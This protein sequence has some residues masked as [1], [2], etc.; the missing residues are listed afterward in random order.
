MDFNSLDVP[1]YAPFAIALPIDAIDETARDNVSDQRSDLELLQPLEAILSS[2]RVKFVGGQAESPDEIKISIESLDALIGK[3][4]SLTGTSQLGIS[5]GFD[6][7][8]SKATWRSLDYAFP[9]YETLDTINSTKQIPV[10]SSDSALEYFQLIKLVWEKRLEWATSDS[11]RRELFCD[12]FGKWTHYSG[13][14]LRCLFNQVLEQLMVREASTCLECMPNLASKWA[15]RYSPEKCPPPKLMESLYVDSSVRLLY[16]RD[17]YINAY[18]DAALKAKH[19]IDI[20]ACYIFHTDCAT[21]YIFLDLIP[22]LA[23]QKNIKVRILF[24][25]MTME[26]QCFHGVLDVI[27]P[28]TSASASTSMPSDVSFIEQLPSGSPPFNYA[29]KKFASTSGLLREILDLAA[30]IPNI[31]YQYWIARDKTSK[32]R[33]KNHSKFHIFD[34]QSGGRVIAGGSNVV[35]RP[36]SLDTDFIVEGDITQMYQQTFNN[37]WNAMKP[38][39]S[40]TSVFDVAEEKKECN[41]S[42]ESYDTNIA[43]NTNDPGLMTKMLFLSS[44]PS[45]SGE[46]VILRKVLGAIHAAEKSIV[47]CM[48]HCN[49]PLQFTLALQAATERGVKV[50]VLSNSIYSCDLRNGQKDL[51]ASLRQM[52]TVAPKVELFVTAMKGG[53]RPPFLHSK[54]VV[55]DANWSAFG[56][57]N[58]WNRSS[59]Y[60][61]EAN[62]FAFS[63]TLASQLLAK[64]EQEKNSYSVQVHS[65]ADCEFFLPTGLNG[66]QKCYVCKHFG[67]FYENC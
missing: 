32:Y 18:I 19:S 37:L 39:C 26:S 10:P 16:S 52:L 44:S 11:E 29:E 6:T 63:D 43:L 65:A 47:L 35:P 33:I 7:R 28:T 1:S 45:S 22:Y 67:P 59:F 13:D 40:N 3:L 58:L 23:T 64:F 42:H 17:N 66:D 60:E 4:S 34:G 46:D 38:F 41:E 5:P 57:W 20:C 48:G 61:M 53:R 56:S 27:K 30:A 36:D 51:F 21:K 15:E 62:V 24:E 8:E 31:E 14:V 12:C 25:L 2:S 49:I 54:Y 9:E 50:S 55:V